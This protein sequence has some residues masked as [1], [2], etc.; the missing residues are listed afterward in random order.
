M[1]QHNS[2]TVERDL[3]QIIEP[4]KFLSKFAS[5][6]VM[7]SGECKYLFAA[8]LS[9]KLRSSCL[10]ADAEISEEVQNVVRF[11]THVKTFQNLLIHFLYILE[12]AIAVTNDVLVAEM[13]V[14]GEPNIVHGP[15]LQ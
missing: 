14:S 8:N 7:V 3:C 2:L 6:F 1:T 5:I 11:C 4:R 15:S 9:S 12:W 10:W 13:K